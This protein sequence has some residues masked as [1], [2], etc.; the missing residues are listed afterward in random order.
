MRRRPERP[1]YLLVGKVVGTWGR[2]GE[3]KVQVLTSFPDRF[4]PGTTLLVGADKVPHVIEG[5][6]WRSSILFLKFKG[7]DAI[8]QAETLVGGDLWVRF[9][10]RVPLTQGE[11]YLYEILGLQVLTEDGR[12]LGTVEEVLETP[13]NDVYVVRNEGKEYLIP[14]LRE[15]VLRVD[16]EEG[17]MVVRLLPGLE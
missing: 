10:D 5:V 8:D 4:V 9:E 12:C 6:K 1:Q 13:S 11:F 17:I 3:L 2:K 16:P 14:A 15:V 7:V